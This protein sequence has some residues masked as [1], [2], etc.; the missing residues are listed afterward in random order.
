MI[1]LNLYVRAKLFIYYTNEE[2]VWEEIKF[3]CIRAL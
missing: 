3:G 2:S 1:K